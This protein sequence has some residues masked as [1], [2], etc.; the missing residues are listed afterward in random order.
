M[1]KLE[2]YNKPEIYVHLKYYLKPITYIHEKKDDYMLKPVVVTILFNG[3]ENSN[4]PKNIIHN[5]KN[6]YNVYYTSLNNMDNVFNDSV[7]K[8]KTNQ[9]NNDDFI[10]FPHDIYEKILEMSQK[11][12]VNIFDVEN[13]ARDVKKNSKKN[14]RNLLTYKKKALLET[15]CYEDRRILLE[16]H[17]FIGLLFSIDKDYTSKTVHVTFK[18]VN[19]FTDDYMQKKSI[20]KKKK[21][22]NPNKQPY[23][24]SYID[25][26]WTNN[27]QHPLSK[28]DAFET[29]TPPYVKIEQLLNILCERNIWLISNDISYCHTI[30]IQLKRLAYPI[31]IS[32]SYNLINVMN[33]NSIH[34]YNEILQ[35]PDVPFL[36][37][38]TK[39]PTNSS[40]TSKLGPHVD[41]I[42]LLELNKEVVL[43][44]LPQMP[45]KY[46]FYLENILHKIRG[47]RMMKI[48]LSGQN[49][50]DMMY[51]TFFTFVV[52]II[53]PIL[54]R[55]YGNVPEERC[56]FNLTE[57]SIAISN[58]KIFKTLLDGMLKYQKDKIVRKNTISKNMCNLY[59]GLQSIVKSENQVSKRKNFVLKK[60]KKYISIYYKLMKKTDCERIEIIVPSDAILLALGG[61]KRTILELKQGKACMLSPDEFEQ[62]YAAYL[63]VIRGEDNG[64]E[65]MAY[66]NLN[67]KSKTTF[68]EAIKKTYAAQNKDIQEIKSQK[69][70]LMQNKLHNQGIEHEGSIYPPNDHTEKQDDQQF[71]RRIPHKSTYYQY[72]SRSSII[73][74]RGDMGEKTDDCN[75]ISSETFDRKQHRKLT[76]GVGK[77]LFTQEHQDNFVIKPEIVEERNDDSKFED[78]L[79]DLDIEREILKKS[80]INIQ[81]EKVSFE[82]IEV[83]LDHKEEI[84]DEIDDEDVLIILSGQHSYKNPNSHKPKSQDKIDKEKPNK[85]HIGRKDYSG[86]IGI[87]KKIIDNDVPPDIDMSYDEFP[88]DFQI[89]EKTL[90]EVPMNKQSYTD[91]FKDIARDSKLDKG[92]ENQLKESKSSHPEKKLENSFDDVPVV[93]TAYEVVGYDNHEKDGDKKVTDKKRESELKASQKP[94]DFDEIVKTSHLE[95]DNNAKSHMAQLEIITKSLTTKKWN[96]LSRIKKF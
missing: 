19:G 85:D 39:F 36:I 51:E 57:I 65:I 77:S 78:E 12:I 4:I 62:L 10:V 92:K 46:W 68:I 84:H 37:I 49:I 15:H 20:L 45:N 6:V 61:F 26:E 33:P 66:Q 17:M 60:L 64:N 16:Y 71:H 30:A 83:E 18:L 79:E 8:N 95:L 55:L 47:D 58:T 75:D 73:V 48:S 90:K 91:S 25:I 41:Y 52:A 2:K 80:T 21:K 23:K 94:K 31:D 9:E 40:V 89:S 53:Y 87:K 81:T 29:H 86:Q 96:N 1:Y 93:V 13:I 43:T 74:M 50:D 28:E 38:S 67:S 22:E 82:D 24:T 14:S 76:L 11:D 44:P 32:E 5:I 69:M 35:H 42:V 7:G 72:G 59:D 56:S 54:E 34:E 70:V 88:P 63:P 27:Q 3:I